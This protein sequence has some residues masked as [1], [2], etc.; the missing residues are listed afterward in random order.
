MFRN[1]LR[2]REVELDPGMR[3]GVF[4]LVREIGR[5]GMGVVWLAERDEGE[6]RQQVAI[7]CII[8]QRSEQGAELFRR[9][10]QILSELRHPSSANYRSRHETE[11]CSA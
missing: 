8:D 11:V 4:K 2:T 6:Y 10:R 1:L 3:L 7:K 5:G 9:E